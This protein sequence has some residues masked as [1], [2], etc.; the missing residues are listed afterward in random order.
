MS[1]IEHPTTDREDTASL[2]AQTDKLGSGELGR[3]R[4]LARAGIEPFDD[5][6]TPV[7]SKTPV[8]RVHRSHRGGRSYN[9]GTESELDPYWNTPPDEIEQTPEDKARGLAAARKEVAD[10]RKQPTA[11]EIEAGRVADAAEIRRKATE[12]WG[13]QV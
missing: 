6:P 2:D 3:A 13:D 8:K 5:D 4:A 7:K 11:E 12:S 10:S 1:L 9:E